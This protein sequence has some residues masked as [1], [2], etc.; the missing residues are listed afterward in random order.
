M[1][2]KMRK[3]CDSEAAAR[4]SVRRPSASLRTSRY[5][6]RSKEPTRPIRQAQG[7]C[8]RYEKRPGWRGMLGARAIHVIVAR[9]GAAE[10]RR[11]GPRR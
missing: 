7:R 6:G 5:N 3:Q 4:E 2:Q 8:R 10:F 11:R 1:L 9:L